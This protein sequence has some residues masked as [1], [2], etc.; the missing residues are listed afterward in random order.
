MGR[1]GLS[2][3]AVLVTVVMYE[4]AALAQAP[5]PPEPGRPFGGVFRGNRTEGTDEAVALTVSVSEAY[6]NDIVGTQS[7]PGGPTVESGLFTRVSSQLSYSKRSDRLR[8]QAGGGL[9]LDYYSNLE[10]DIPQ[11]VDTYQGQAGIIFSTQRAVVQASQRISYYP[12]FGFD[13]SSFA[14]PSNPGVSIGDS[15][16]VRPGP[17][18]A[19]F[20]SPVITYATTASASFPLGRRS[21]ATVAYS[22]SGS[23]E[24]ENWPTVDGQAASANYSHSISRSVS[25]NASY[26]Y[27]FSNYR[28]PGLATT[29]F[30]SHDLNGGASWSRALSSTRS[31]TISGSAGQ[32]FIDDNAVAGLGSS[33]AINAHGSF[34]FQFARSWTVQS[35]VHRSIQYVQGLTT[36]YFGVGWNIGLQ[37]EPTRRLELSVNTGVVNSDSVVANAERTDYDTRNTFINVRYA[38]GANM[39]IFG[40]YARTHYEFG[41]LADLPSGVAQQFDREVVQVGLTFGHLLFRR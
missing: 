10:T 17:D 2:A 9:G 31:V 3:M 33:N 8:F 40:Q 5:L 41:P 15:P 21:T 20:E 1:S 32:S 14:P 36:P 4:T 16:G 23:E 26:G 34:G 27:Q 12:Y 18:A 25:L 30:K 35:D 6:D 38:L 39:A 28:S 22:Y 7:S 24:S 37:G 11:P 13:L 19:L 29:E